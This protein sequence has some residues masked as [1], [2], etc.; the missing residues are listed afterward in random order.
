MDRAVRRRNR[1]VY[2]A[3]A[4]ALAEPRRASH[5]NFDVLINRVRADLIREHDSRRSAERSW[6]WTIFVFGFNVIYCR[7]KRRRAK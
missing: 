7:V 1:A 5:F 3:E 6:R 4:A 2:G